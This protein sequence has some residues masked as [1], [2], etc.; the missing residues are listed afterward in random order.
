MA[1]AGHGCVCDLCGCGVGAGSKVFSCRLC[2]M[3]ACVSCIW[4]D[5]RRRPQQAEK[6]GRVYTTPAAATSEPRPSPA[7]PPPPSYDTIGPPSPRNGQA[8]AVAVPPYREMPAG[9]AEVAGPPKYGELTTSSQARTP[10]S[11]GDLY[12]RGSGGYGGTNAPTDDDDAAA[13]DHDY[14]ASDEEVEPPPFAFDSVVRVVGVDDPRT[15]GKL[16]TVIGFEPCP[17][18]GAGIVVLQRKRK[19]VRVPTANVFNVVG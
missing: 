15:D 17:R 9:G 5:H 19:V 7:E 12:V 13:A 2:N 14:D 16:M 4:R 1:A 3:D 10:P 11:Y 6:V 18:G 8:A